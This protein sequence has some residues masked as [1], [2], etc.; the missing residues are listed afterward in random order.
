MDKDRSLRNR[1]LFAC[2]GA[3]LALHAWYY[4]PFL[5]DDALISLRYARRFADGLGLTWT[6]G[7]RVEGYTD[8]GW[9]LIHAAAS[10]LGLDLIASAR[11]I[12]FSGALMAVLAV[13]VCPRT[14]LLSGRRLVTGGLALALSAPLAVWAIG[15]LEQGF[16]AGLL[17]VGLMMIDRLLER[18]QP[19]RREAWGTGLLFAVLAIMRAD[20]ALLFALAA[21][22]I[23]LSRGR[24]LATWRLVTRLAVLPVAFVMLQLAFRWH[25]YGELVPN[26]ALVKVSLTAERIRFGLEHVA[27][28]ALALNVLWLGVLVS[29]GACLRRAPRHRYVVPLCITIG[30][31]GYV[32][33][34]GGDIFPGWRQVLLGIV[35][36]GMIVAEGGT[37]LRLRRRRTRVA[38]GVGLVA[39]LVAYPAG[40][41]VDAENRRAKRERWEW[42]G[43]GLA[44]SLQRAFGDE[45]PLL[46]V[47]A[48]GALPFWSEL[49][50]L[51]MLG[52][53]DKYIATHRPKSFG[54][55]PVGHELGDGAYLW[56]RAPDIIVF[57]NA[58]GAEKP[59]F[60]G[61]RQLL[62]RREFP[63]RYQLVRVRGDRGNRRVGI[64]YVRFEGGHLGIERSP[65]RVVIPGFFLSK[66]VPGGAR[67][68]GDDEIYTPVTA[69]HP[70]RLDRLRL[71]RGTWQLSLEPP[72]SDA[73]VAWRCRR[74]LRSASRPALP[75]P[76]PSDDR[77]TLKIRRK[78]RYVDVLVALPV[79]R[80]GS[81]PL[82]RV[83]AERVPSSGATQRCHFTRGPLVVPLAALADPKPEGTAYNHPAA[84]PLRSAGLR[85]EL[86]EPRY[87]T[88]LEVSLDRNDSYRIRYERDGELVD[89]TVI[90]PR[91]EGTG[92]AVHRVPVPDDVPIRGVDRVVVLPRR[93]DE[94]YSLG[95]LVLHEGTELPGD[96]P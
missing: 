42:D 36:L 17:A 85:I 24:R 77:P 59:V 76:V 22:G 65:D 45:Q 93:G 34:V 80:E 66:T 57:N 78:H 27:Q 4:Y 58:S 32:A 19:P 48:A 1:L 94:L 54:R 37:H 25:Y 51:D 33:F 90:E 5:S 70:A 79:G 55:G 2:A 44:H 89:Q 75:L 82:R 12:G 50:S 8:L 74:H 52:L 47:D 20:G 40:Q 35:P 92:L 18:E 29:L 15:G 14:L 81:V 60:R 56:R 69:E 39:M 10:A 7:E 30:W 26:T 38:F 63:A 43:Y 68:D 31:W 64:L 3:L 21:L 73:V 61:G 49:P 67:L 87:P 84:V 16:M 96:A 11:A 83:V 53:N 28:G 95:H 72:S 6:G 62:R 46:A 86:D 41:T 71:E 91:P 9:V 88:W 23:L 13:S